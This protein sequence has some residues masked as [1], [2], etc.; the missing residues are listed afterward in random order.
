[1]GIHF[2]EMKVYI[3][4]QTC[5]QTFLTALLI[6]AKDWEQPRYPAT[7]GLLHKCNATIPRSEVHP[8][9]GGRTTHTLEVVAPIPWREMHLYHA[10]RCAH[11]LEVLPYL[12]VTL[13]HGTLPVMKRDELLRIK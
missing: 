13:H 1:M 7:G 5:T 8:Y 2:K 9:P 10:G 4:A 12:G 6:I 11:T 3:H